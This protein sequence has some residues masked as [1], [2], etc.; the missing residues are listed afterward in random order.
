MLNELLSKAGFELISEG[1][2]ALWTPD[3]DAEKACIE[4]GRKFASD[5]KN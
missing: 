5:I 3:S 4:F 1:I 2:K